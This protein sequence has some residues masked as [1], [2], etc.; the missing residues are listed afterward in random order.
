MSELCFN[1]FMISSK[2]SIA[3]KWG[4]ARSVQSIGW[5]PWRIQQS[6]NRSLILTDHRIVPRTELDA[7][8]E[9]GMYVDPEVFEIHL[10]FLKKYCDILPLS[11]LGTRSDSI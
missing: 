1:R 9:P 3:I 10:T 11:A 5:T 2:L 4:L 6:C 7:R 8:I